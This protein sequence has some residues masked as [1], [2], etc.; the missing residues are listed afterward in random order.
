[1]KL[2]EKTVNKEKQALIIRKYQRYLK[3]EKALSANTL[4]AYLTDLD[5]LLRFLEAENIDMLSVTLDDLQRFAA[6]LHDIGIHPRSQARIMSGIKSFFHFLIM[7]DYREDDPSELLEGP[8]IGFK[9]PEV[10]T[11]EEIDTI[12]AT[13]DMSKKEGQRNRAILETLYSCGLRVSELCN[14]KLSE[15]YFDEGFIKVEGK[16]SKQRLVPISPRAIKEIKYWL[17]DRNVGK[18]KKGF[19]DYVFLARWGNSISRIMVFH[20]I[21]ELAEKAGITKNISPHTFRHSFATHLLEGGANLRAIQCMLGHESIATTE[22][23]THIDRNMLRSEIIEHHPR[24]IK[25][26]K[27]TGF[28]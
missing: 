5:K 26:R 6:G 10:L 1:M 3:L 9:L 15:L 12:I 4:D 17:L 13:V 25:Y 22:I 7:A 14:L 8:K 21:K 20:L 23:Y 16:G 18:I 11:V 19:E 2:D 24:N 28:H 27:E